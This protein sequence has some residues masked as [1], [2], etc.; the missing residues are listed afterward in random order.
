[1][2]CQISRGLEATDCC[3]VLRQNGV[4]GGLTRS[5]RVA[6]DPDSSSREMDWCRTSEQVSRECREQRQGRVCGPPMMREPLG[7]QDI[8]RPGRTMS[9]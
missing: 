7:C 3:E 2:I 6:L 8:L 4:P 1:M 9:R 5:S